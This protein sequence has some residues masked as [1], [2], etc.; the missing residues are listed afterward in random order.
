YTQLDLIEFADNS[1]LP[2]IVLADPTLQLLR[3]NGNR[4]ACLMNDV[5]SYY[6]EIVVEGS[7]FNLVKLIQENAGI[8]LKEAVEDAVNIVNAHTVEFLEYEK[9]VQYSDTT[10]ELA[11]KKYIEGIKKQISA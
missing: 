9:Q 4:I 5:F 2:E 11:V 8:G 1:T 7:Q 3:R 6:K 10:T